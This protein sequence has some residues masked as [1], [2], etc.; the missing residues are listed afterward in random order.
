MRPPPFRAL[1]QLHRAPAPGARF[2][3]SAFVGDCLSRPPY[4]FPDGTRGIF[5]VGGQWD[6]GD[7]CLL[8]DPAGRLLVK[9]M[10]WLPSGSTIDDQPA[11][12]WLMRCNGPPMWAE[13]CEVIGP[14]IASYYSDDL[15]QKHP[16][17]SAAMNA[18]NE[19]MRRLQS[20]TDLEANMTPQERAEWET[21][22]AINPE[23][24]AIRAVMYAE[25]AGEGGAS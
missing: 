4:N 14:L 22:L 16:E 7:I 2:K 24:A 23:W 6:S 19:Q 17:H 1:R 13:G 15:R 25:M 20:F 3:R 8:R 21:Y 9:E 18:Q 11:Q 10:F 5:E 12:G